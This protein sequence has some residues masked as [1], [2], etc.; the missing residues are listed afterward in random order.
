MPLDLPVTQTRFR[1]ASTIAV[2][3][4]SSTRFAVSSSPDRRRRPEPSLRSFGPV[5][6][7]TFVLVFALVA[8]TTF[9]VTA[10]A[11]DETA[12]ERGLRRVD[13]RHH[14]LVGATVV[15]RPGETVENATIVLRDGLIVAFGPTVSP[16]S[17][18]R[19]HDCS[20]LV[21]YAGFVEP[22]LP[23]DA[24]RDETGRS[25][26]WNETLVNPQRSALDGA[27]VD[28][29]R[30]KKLRAAGFTAAAIVP[31]GGI[32]RGRSA[33]VALVGDDD[34]LVESGARVLRRDAYQE[35]A[36]ETGRPYPT[37][38]MGAIALVRQT[39]SDA[40]WHLAAR[41]LIRRR[42][43][44]AEPPAP[45]AALEALAGDGTPPLLFNSSRELQVLRAARL[46]REFDRSLTVLGSGTEFRQLRGIVKTKLRMILPLVFPDAPKVDSIDGA[47]SVSLRQL[48][49]WEQAPTNPRRLDEAGMFVALTTDKAE[50]IDDFWANLRTAIRHGL[51]P[52]RA[53][54]M[55]TTRPAELLGMSDRL[56]VIRP[57][58]QAHLAVFDGDAFAKKSRVREV[59][60]GGRQYV[61]TK[62]SSDSKHR[63]VAPASDDQVSVTVEVDG[64]KLT[65]IRGTDKAVA[66]SVRRDG[67]RISGIVDGPDLGAS[68]SWMISATVDGDQLFA[69]LVDDQGRRRNVVASKVTMDDVDDDSSSATSDVA[70]ETSLVP[71]LTDV[72]ATWG[73]PFGAFGYQT[74]PVARTT[75]LR[76]ATVWTAAESGVLT[77]AAVLIRDGRIAWVGDAAD[78][79][80]D[81]DV[82]VVDATGL[83]ITPG[84]IDCH[85]HT[86]ISGGVNEMGQRVTSE[87]RIDDVINPDDVNWYRQLTGGVTA[88]NQLHG[89]AN[90]IGGQNSVVKIRWGVADPRDM[91]IHGAPSG[92]KFALGENPKRVAAR[93]D[94]PDEYPLTRMGVNTLIVDRLA[95]GRDYRAAHA[96]YR[97]LSPQARR[98]VMPP[99]RNLELE[100]LG[101]IVA[102]ERLI[103]CHSYRQD[104]ILMLCRV[105]QRFGFRIGTFQHV[106]EGYKIAEAV[107]ETALGGSTFADWW[108]YKFEVIDAIPQNPAIMT[109]VGVCVSI[110][111]DSNEHARRLN[112][113]AGKSVKY[114]GMMPHEALKL[115]TINPAIQLGIADRTGSIE[116]G[117]DADLAVWSGD[118]LDYYSR[119]VRTF[120]DGGELYSIER[121][122]TLRAMAQAERLRLIQKVLARDTKDGKRGND[123]KKS[124]RRT[125]QEAAA[126]LS[127]DASW[128]ERMDALLRA[129]IDPYE[130]TPGDCGCGD[131]GLHRDEREHAGDHR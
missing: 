101:E 61:V 83:H 82:F 39:L 91:L 84:I 98:D 66:R 31:R 79:P 54:A 2:M 110:N 74:P 99:R 55:L 50:S 16:P 103:H 52:S 11:Q 43:D 34:P 106:L 111:S 94:R 42:P 97:A 13:P 27:G 25:R 56:G 60:V 76:G 71:P 36:F 18:A 122:A 120:V 93:S 119:C 113:E 114:G 131:A 118:P 77:D 51:A 112:T 127:I 72:P 116:V 53:L 86:G 100:A 4:D 47:E 45:N 6:L 126:E 63:F 123:G 69:T 87:V 20:G 58:A 81:D 8:V 12:P 95:A 107:R 30:A 68:G 73:H 10:V 17:G 59:W 19:V 130:L 26:H 64:K 108:A 115:V 78:A 38:Q 33:V 80:N 102:G 23:V 129:G 37:S 105:A 5:S 21:I 104:E 3:N 9:S 35:F 57:G 92:I 62:P 121:D 46:A 117:K 29:E 48:M 96:R 125:F 14:A 67:G 41:D 7:A 15:P 44:L 75:L 89:S 90:A 40:D 70:K 24:P 88:A 65:V 22:H 128:Q 49:T 85:S 124:E 109:E 32:F 28:G 1:F